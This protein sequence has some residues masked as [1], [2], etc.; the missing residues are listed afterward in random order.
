MTAY[1]LSA[2][3]FVKKGKVKE[4]Y[5]ADDNFLFQFSNRVSVFDQV[6]P[7]LIPRKG[8]SLNRCSAHW[9]K[10]AKNLGINTHF[11][12][13]P[14]PDQMLV[15]RA[16]S[17][18]LRGEHDPDYE[19]VG[20]LRNNY[21]I[22]LEVIG[23]DYIVGSM[24]DRVQ[25]GEVKPEE[26]GYPADHDPKKI[27]KGEKLPERFIEV[28]TKFEKFDRPVP[29]DEAYRI[30]GMMPAEYNE[31]KEIVS[32]MFDKMAD[33]VEPRGLIHMDGKMEFA[34]GPHRELMLIDTF[35]TGDEDRF[36][37]KAVYDAS[38]G[39]PKYEIVEVSKEFV[40]QY[41]RRIGHHAALEA[42]RKAKTREPLIP[43][44]PD[45]EIAE[46]SRL[47]LKLMEMITGEQADGP[48]SPIDQT[49]WD[50]MGRQQNR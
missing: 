28:T 37:D 15:R 14:A 20:E 42:A 31:M 29:I 2:L 46:T 12:D 34:F 35:G 5:E 25:R 47:Y 40:R 44:L 16:G 7:S 50:E 41:Y 49:I 39:Q 10:A 45:P 8:E 19:K 9:F 24:Y 26:L 17:F 32:M 38:E 21:Q 1:D 18:P 23:R 11:L 4:V 22:P 36:V 33:E 43:P 30:A 27:K 3:K 13:M 48:F 6:I